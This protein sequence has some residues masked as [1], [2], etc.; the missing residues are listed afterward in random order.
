M[1][2]FKAGDSSASTNYRPI[3]VITFFTKAFEKIVYNKLFNFICNNN[4]LYD[5]QYGFRK[6]R[7]TQQ[8]IITLVD[9]IT[10][11]QDIGNIVITL[12]I[13]LKKAFD[14]IDHRILL[15]KLYSY[16]IKG[17][18]FKWIESYLT[19]RSQ[20]VIFDGKVSETPSMKCGVPQG[21]ILGPLVFI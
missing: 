1:P 9:R 2:I 6:G 16:R 8:A 12:L 7:S 3:S 17:T 18:M 19:G 11:S 21:S 20:Y 5:H 14:T 4:I 10:K 13:D 15:R